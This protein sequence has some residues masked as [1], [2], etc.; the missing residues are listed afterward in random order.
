MPAKK[1]LAAP[2]EKARTTP[3]PAK[4]NG[5]GGAAYYPKPERNPDRKKRP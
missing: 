3:K 5:K 1:S 2:G 4:M